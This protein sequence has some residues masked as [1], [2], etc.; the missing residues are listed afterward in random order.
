MAKLRNAGYNKVC[1]WYKNVTCI[2]SIKTN[3]A[4]TNMQAR[5]I[6]QDLLLAYINHGNCHWTLLVRALSEIP[7]FFNAEFHIGVGHEA[8]ESRVL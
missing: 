7:V 6:D 8:Q 3:L 1:K 2:L 5:M 4:I